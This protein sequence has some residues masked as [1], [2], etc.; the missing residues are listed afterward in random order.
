MSGR[1]GRANEDVGL[2]ITNG[3]VGRVGLGRAIGRVKSLFGRVDG[4]GRV[5]GRVKGLLLGRVEGLGRILGRGR[6]EGR[7]MGREDGRVTGLED[8]R[9][10]GRE[11][12][13]GRAVGR[14]T[15][16]GPRKPPFDGRAS[17][18]GTSD[19]DEA[20]KNSGARAILKAQVEI[21]SARRK[22]ESL[23]ISISLPKLRNHRLL[24]E[25]F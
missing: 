1:L 6:I 11:D 4:L 15:S 18:L 21:R 12:G 14:F 25:H 17:A 23:I 20:E 5:T 13:R 8:G 7:V 10:L 9:G 24:S 2:G 22:K 16:A 3:F 19:I